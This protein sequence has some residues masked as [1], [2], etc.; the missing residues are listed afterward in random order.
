VEE[1]ILGKFLSNL[2]RLMQCSAMHHVKKL[3]LLGKLIAERGPE[4][5]N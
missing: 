5:G 2:E 1:K 3:L 4:N